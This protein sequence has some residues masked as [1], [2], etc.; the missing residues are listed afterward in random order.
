MAQA[1]EPSQEQEIKTHLSITE[2]NLPAQL[3]LLFQLLGQGKPAQLSSSSSHRER[4]ISSSTRAG[5]EVGVGGLSTAAPGT[6]RTLE[7]LG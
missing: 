3:H 1:E 4:G 6:D 2:P 5:L 7:V